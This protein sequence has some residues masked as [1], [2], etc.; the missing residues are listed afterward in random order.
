MSGSDNHSLQGLNE[1]AALRAIL[2]GT[3]SETGERFF[4]ALVKSLTQALDTHGA[5]VTEFNSESRRLST[6]ALWL[7]GQL[8]GNCEFEIAG[9]PCE[10]V[11]KEARMVHI[12]DRLT[13]VFPKDL[14]ALTLGLVSYIGVPLKGGD[15]ELLGHL[16]VFDRR[17]MPEKPRTLALFQIFASQ[18]AAELKRLRAEAVIREREEKLSGVMASTMDAIIEL[19]ENFKVALVNP[20]AANAFKCCE[21]WLVGK[22]FTL[23]LSEESRDRFRGCALQLECGSPGR[24]SLW[25]PGGLEAAQ[26]HGAMFAAEATISCFQA[27][28]RRHYALVLRDVNERLDAERKIQSLRAETEYLRDEVNALR[29]FDKIVGQSPA[30]SRA[31]NDVRQ[32]AATDTTVLI[33]GETGTGKELFARAIHAAS[34][35]REKPM[36]KVNCGAIPSGLIESEFFGHEKGAFTGATSRREGRF[37][38]ADGGT[39]F[40]DEVGELPLDLQSKLLR[41]L[42]EGEFEPV[43]SSKTRRVDT[44]LIAA[45]NRNLFLQMKD[46]K[47][48]EDLYYRLHVFPLEIPPLRERG[49]DIPLL[50]SAFAE[51]FARRMGRKLEPLSPDDIRRLKTYSWPGNVRELVSVIERAVITAEDGRLNLRRALPEAA[52]PP[53]SA[54]ATR[55]VTPM[56]NAAVQIHTIQEMEN[57][58][59]QNLLRALEAAGW[60]VAGENGAAR[61]L[62]MNP[63]TLNSRMRA[64]GIRR[65]RAAFDYYAQPDFGAPFR[66]AAG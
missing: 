5:W 62:G 50:A 26:A 46:G 35:R 42:Q 60:R 52:E 12:P 13:E 43:G 59:K 41:V 48:R 61:L 54:A 16:A 36:I 8:C 31:L 58:E 19:D 47:F 63:S 2:E 15:G 49:E 39:L 57:F 10:V 30:L 45:T 18:A 14:E 29:N 25:I 3:A 44:R 40:L 1:D 64:L 9:T 65:S 24:Q 38:L 37:A 20:A 21:D 32:V 28:Q 11:I 27:R 51:R 66:V 6:L 56:T 53:I 23:F 4:A 33:L 17:P 7:D 22:D 55:S 34:A